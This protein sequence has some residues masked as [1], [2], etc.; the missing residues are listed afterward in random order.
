MHLK[1]TIKLFQKML[2][3]IGF[4]ATISKMS[5][6]ENIRFRYFFWLSSFPVTPEPISHTIFWKNSVRSFGCTKTFCPNCD[7]LFAVISRKYK[8]GVKCDILMIVI[9]GVNMIARQMTVFLSST[10]WA[11]PVGIFHYCN[12]RLSKFNSMLP[13]PPL[14]FCSGL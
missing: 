7:S 5:I 2:W 4:W 11:L 10:L 8:N 1:D 6:L 14:A 13:Q 9:P 12:S 3:I